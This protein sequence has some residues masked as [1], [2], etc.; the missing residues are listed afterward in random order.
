MDREGH[1]D[2]RFFIGTEVEKSPAYGQRTLF[3]VGY[4]PTNEILARA[5]NNNCPTY[6]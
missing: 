1:E 2:V 6:T 3:V 5:L 4:Q